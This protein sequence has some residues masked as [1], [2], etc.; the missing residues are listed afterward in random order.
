MWTDVAVSQYL[1]Q[2]GSINP[3]PFLCITNIKNCWLN[4]LLCTKFNKFICF[5]HG[6]ATSGAFSDT[7]NC[8]LQL[9]TVKE[10]L[11]YVCWKWDIE[12]LSRNAGR[13]FIS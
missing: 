12:P 1:S 5:S 2:I 11:K 10:K 9:S 6:G 4:D 13:A 8:H 3:A 7:G